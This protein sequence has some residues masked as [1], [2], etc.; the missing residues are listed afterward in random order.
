MA[1][2]YLLSGTDV[3]IVNKLEQV[4]AA[5]L[6]RASGIRVEIA[7]A[8][9][10]EISFQSTRL[11]IHPTP[12]D[13]CSRVC[14]LALSQNLFASVV[15]DIRVSTFVAPYLE[16]A[17]EH[18][19]D[20]IVNPDSTVYVCFQT[21]ACKYTES[22]AIV[23]TMLALAGTRKRNTNVTVAVRHH[24]CVCSHGATECHQFQPKLWA[25]ATQDFYATCKD[26]ECAMI[27]EF[28]DDPSG[29]LSDRAANDEIAFANECHA[30]NPDKNWSTV[31]PHRITFAC[32][33]ANLRLMQHTSDWSTAQ[34][35]AGR[36]LQVRMRVV[37]TKQPYFRTLVP[38]CGTVTLSHFVTLR[39]GTDAIQIATKLL[40]HRKWS[41]C[42]TL[43][44]EEGDMTLQN[45]FEIASRPRVSRLCVELTSANLDT[46]RNIVQFLRINCNTLHTLELSLAANSALSTEAVANLVLQQLPLTSGVRHLIV[47][48]PDSK[49]AAPLVSAIVRNLSHTKLRQLTL[50]VASAAAAQSIAAMFER[51]AADLPALDHLNLV[52]STEM[53]SAGIEQLFLDPV[54]LPNVKR[55]TSFS[56]VLTHPEQ[57]AAAALLVRKI[58]TSLSNIRSL[59]VRV[60]YAPDA[61]TA[62]FKPDYAIATAITESAVNLRRIERLVLDTPIL[63]AQLLDIIHVKPDPGSTMR[64]RTLC[65]NIHGANGAGAKTHALLH[66]LAGCSGTLRELQLNGQFIDDCDNPSLLRHVMGSL[67]LSTL[68]LSECKLGAEL[69]TLA[70]KHGPPNA[71]RRARASVLIHGNSVCRCARKRKRGGS[72]CTWKHQAASAWDSRLSLLAFWRPI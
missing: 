12:S 35:R 67:C 59:E 18:A 22:A 44:V 33:F 69:A 17:L 46:M 65:V 41:E 63:P 58:V 66:A 8:E 5:D 34:W 39:C 72:G 70:L 1:E 71:S 4:L 40:E 14:S 53:R 68:D 56:V 29:T 52:L 27:H 20:I 11:H 43:C 31:G 55:L 36:V 10:F 50:P 64:L 15:R 49:K 26:A 25:L 23:R 3:D 9:A 54:R 51:P 28:V 42:V 37:E 38:I 57:Q 61:D 2:P 48:G 6:R 13:V 7:G 45:Q 62:V 19:A 47:S 16:R 60:R 32:E 30:L 24:M 21:S